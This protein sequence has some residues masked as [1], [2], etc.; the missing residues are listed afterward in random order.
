[1]I[2]PLN[3]ADHNNTAPPD[4]LLLLDLGS[5]SMF[6]VFKDFRNFQVK[7]LIKKAQDVVMIDISS[8]DFTAN[9]FGNKVTEI[10]PINTTSNVIVTLSPSKRYLIFDYLKGEVLKEIQPLRGSTFSTVVCPREL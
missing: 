4:S 2:F 10:V 1:M 6:G 9:C 5:R 3:R 7:Q 8:F